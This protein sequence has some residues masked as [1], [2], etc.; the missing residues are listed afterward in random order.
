MHNFKPSRP[1][2]NTNALFNWLTSFLPLLSS[3][4]C[5]SFSHCLQKELAAAQQGTL[6]ATTPEAAAAAAQPPPLI[7]AVMFGAPNVGDA[8]FTAD[9]NTR[10]NARNI[11]YVA[12]IVPQ[13]PCAGHM[14]LCSLAPAASAEDEEGEDADS[15]QF[16][17]EDGFGGDAAADSLSG[18]DGQG[19]SSWS[20]G[21]ESL[22]VSF[23]S[24]RNK[25]RARAYT[26]RHR[27]NR[28]ARASILGSNDM[29]SSDSGSDV[30]DVDAVSYA[31]LG[32]QLRLEP[33][34]MPVQQ[35]AWRLLSTYR[36]VRQREGREGGR[37]G[38]QG[39]ASEAVA[40][41]TAR[42]LSAHVER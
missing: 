41:L 27:S 7:T 11:E 38:E 6:P 5:F 34:D 23:Y 37:K 15:E 31:R 22:N 26:S 33:L 30:G 3:L 20:G 17:S 2:L 19:E 40:M 4:C 18:G 25:L 32:G 10:I 42:R 21:L 29:S 12:D 1:K 8:P 36:Q 28:K 16:G 35:D 24:I 39:P 9:L 13:L 14:P